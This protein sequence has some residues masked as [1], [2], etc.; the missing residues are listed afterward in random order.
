MKK[1][2]DDLKKFYE[3][4]RYTSQLIT[5]ENQQILLLYNSKSKA[6]IF[7]LIYLT[8]TDEI[9]IGYLEKCNNSIQLSCT[10]MVKIEATSV[11]SIVKIISEIENDL[12]IKLNQNYL[13]DE[14]RPKVLFSDCDSIISKFMSK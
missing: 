2:F 7:G 13:D 8:N 10:Q 5:D 6:I 4:N 11:M 1:I 3:E 14:M 9:D 12:L